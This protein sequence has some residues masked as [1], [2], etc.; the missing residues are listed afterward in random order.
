METLRGKSIL[1]LPSSPTTEVRRTDPYRTTPTTSDRLKETRKRGDW[2]QGRWSTVGSNKKPTD[3]N[4]RFFVGHRISRP[5]YFYKLMET[6][7]F[8]VRC[9]TLFK[10]RMGDSGSQD[11][12]VTSRISTPPSFPRPPLVPDLDKYVTGS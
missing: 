8:R 4:R 1:T 10:N 6:G 5:V 9:W 3:L 11:C 12:T 7:G 2:G